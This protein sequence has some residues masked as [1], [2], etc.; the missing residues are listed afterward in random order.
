MLHEAQA[1]DCLLPP[2]D[3]QALDL[4]QTLSDALDTCESR[5]GV[6]QRTHNLWRRAAHLRARNGL[7][8]AHMAAA[9]PPLLLSAD[10]YI[11]LR[12]TGLGTGLHLG[13]GHSVRPLGGDSVR[14]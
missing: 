3:R 1:S 13:R 2:L 7:L 10:I 5:K 12:G 14:R 11:V 6:G 9:L 4:D 8:L